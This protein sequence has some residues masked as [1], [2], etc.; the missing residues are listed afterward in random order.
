MELFSNQDNRIKCGKCNTEFDLNQN[1]DGC[2]LCGF[3]KKSQKIISDEIKIVSAKVQEH[4][5]IEY[6]Q[7]PPPIKLKS[8]LVI[9]DDET[10]TWGAWLMFNDFFA[11]KFLSRVLAWKL[12]KESSDTIVLSNLM[13]DSINLISKHNLSHLKGFP[14]LKKD[15]EGSRLVHH[16]L[17]TFAN[18]GLVTAEPI[19]KA[20]DD[21]WK[22]KWN[23]IKV[24]LTKEGLEF[25]QLK[26]NVFDEGKTEQILT[27]E[28]KDWFVDYYKKLDKKGYKEYS[29]LEE[30]YNFLKSGN[31]GNKDLWS[32][33]ENNE[34]FKQHILSRSERARNDEKKFKKQLYN[35]ARSFASAKISLLR[36]LGIVKDKRNDYTIIGE[37]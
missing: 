22:E 25:A 12:H 3:G 16:F 13:S 24:S 35:Y 11:P 34:K 7:I 30:V 17:R 15:K 6:L 29:V 20:I 2:P 4:K 1:K 21:V 8:G 33:F 19:E 36:E 27:P 37:L 14:N 26:N 32:W 5:T 18:M 31:N 10:K 23:K 28:E 9:A